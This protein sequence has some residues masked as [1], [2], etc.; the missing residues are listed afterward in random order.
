LLFAVIVGADLIRDLVTE[1][2]ADEIR[3]YLESWR[4]RSEWESVTW[5]NV[6]TENVF[7]VLE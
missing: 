1:T 5:F 2:I 7:D 4:E 6:L 3:S